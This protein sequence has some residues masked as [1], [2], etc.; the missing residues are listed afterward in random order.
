MIDIVEPVGIEDI[1][2]AARRCEGLAIRTPIVACQASSSASNE[3]IYLKLECLQ[4]VGSF[5]VRPIGNVIR[6]LAG[7]EL[8]GGIYTSSSG[9]SALGVAWMA[10]QLGIPSTALVPEGASPAKLAP[11]RALGCAVETL[12]FADWWRAIIEGG[13]PGTP[14]RYV[15]AVRDPA[16][17]AGDGT[18][19]LEI[20]EQLADCDAIFTPFGG[21][22]LISGVGC[23]IRALR[24]D[25]SIVA[26]ELESAAPLTGAFKA[27]G[28]VDV[29]FYPG[30]VS[31]AG[32]RSVLPEMW[33]L[34]RLV[35][36]ETIT[37]SLA[38]VAAA[39]STVARGNHVIAEG[40]GAL[41]VAA[42]L[43][44]RHG[45]RKVCAV[46]SGG[47]LDTATLLH[48]LDGRRS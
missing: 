29:P 42:A 37:V 33:P 38:E 17:L 14:G 36:D 48:I 41:S 35:V 31:G 45:Y 39:I 6:S 5:K 32:A 30:F 34:L 10:A 12:S 18:I 19:G 4:P 28:P 7:D 16:A 44:G 20:V 26:C 3:K 2:A 40:A 8:A 1:R 25:I 24:P 9:N 11:V 27:G 13:R 22:G 43:S 47:N 23:A 15:D 46:V 21:G